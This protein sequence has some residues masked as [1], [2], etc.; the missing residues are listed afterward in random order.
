MASMPCYARPRTPAA[1]TTACATHATPLTPHPGAEHAG[2]TLLV[3]M[4]ER[5]L[6]RTRPWLP[7]TTCLRRV[8]NDVAG[9]RAYVAH[10]VQTADSFLPV[11][12]CAND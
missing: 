11:I 2:D 8:Q 1:P 7:A 9:L 5:S 12:K 6:R 4:E 3:Y 10:K